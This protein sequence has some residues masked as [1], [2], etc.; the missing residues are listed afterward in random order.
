MDDELI[1]ELEKRGTAEVTDSGVCQV[2]QAIE[3]SETHTKFLLFGRIVE[4][5]IAPLDETCAKCKSW[6]QVF[7][8]IE[9]CQEVQQADA[10]ARGFHIVVCA[11]QLIE[12]KEE[13][14]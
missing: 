7:D 6:K 11:N 3:E 1:R 2:M 10:K 13:S 12:S 14:E 5:E 9:E 4:H 8:S